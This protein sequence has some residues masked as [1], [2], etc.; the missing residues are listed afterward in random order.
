MH[1]KSRKSQISLFFTLGILL[2]ILVIFAIIFQVISNKTD[3][4]ATVAL[5]YEFQE[6]MPL[7][8][9]CIRQ[10]VIDSI[11]IVSDRGGYYEMPG[12]FFDGEKDIAYHYYGN[13]SMA[14]SD[15]AVADQ[16]EL[17][18]DEN[19]YSCIKIVNNNTYN[20]QLEEKGDPISSAM[21]GDDSISFEVDYPIEMIKGD[22]RH[23]ERS[24]RFTVEGIRLKTM[25]ELSRQIASEQ[26]KDPEN[27]CMSCIA[28]LGDDN[29]VFIDTIPEK[30]E[31]DS[32]MAL[33]FMMR[34]IRFRQEDKPYIFVMAHE[35]EI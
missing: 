22:V 35:H 25:L 11:M 7:L 33:I 28:L 21:I 2:L 16:L 8:D 5:P 32:K 34:D 3:E 20:I 6:M 31:D 1:E 26:E 19:I 18:I 9:G 4:G 30:S 15:G 17:F 24:F 29:D 10:V 13:K 23:V 27:I 12:H 14:P